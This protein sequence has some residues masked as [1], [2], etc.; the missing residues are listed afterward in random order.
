MRFKQPIILV[1]LLTTSLLI[2]SIPFWIFDLNNNT[3]IVLRCDLNTSVENLIEE[4]K[5]EGKNFTVPEFLHLY[6]EVTKFHFDNRNSSDYNDLIPY[7]V[8][9]STFYDLTP[10]SVIMIYYTCI[11]NTKEQ[12]MFLVEMDEL[13]PEFYSFRKNRMENIKYSQNLAI[14]VRLYFHILLVNCSAQVVFATIIAITYLILWERHSLHG[15]LQLCYVLLEAIHRTGR[16]IYLAYFVEDKGAGNKYIY[17]ANYLESCAKFDTFAEYIQISKLFW[18]TILVFDLWKTFGRGIVLLGK[19]KSKFVKYFA[20]AVLSPAVYTC[21]GLI[22]QAW[23]WGYDCFYLLER[24]NETAFQIWRNTPSI[25]LFVCNLFFVISCYRKS[26]VM[27]KEGEFAQRNVTSRTDSSSRTRYSQV[28]AQVSPDGVLKSKYNTDCQMQSVILPYREGVMYTFG[29]KFISR[30]AQGE[31]VFVDLKRS[32]W[33]WSPDSMFQIGCEDGDF[34]VKPGEG[35]MVIKNGVI[36]NK[37]A[38]PWL[39]FGDE[40]G[41]MKYRND[42]SGG[43]AMFSF[44]ERKYTTNWDKNGRNSAE[45]GP[46]NGAGLNFTPGKNQLIFSHIL[47]HLSLGNLKNARLVCKQWDEQVSPLVRKK[48]IIRFSNYCTTPSMRFSWVSHPGPIGRLTVH[49]PSQ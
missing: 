32:Q 30:E 9:N 5:Q 2:L 34:F 15:H 27:Q 29:D 45:S 25:F 33:N 40:L 1:V 4:F 28:V 6:G 48:S 10:N 23:V 49:S 12:V 46:E 36:L 44:Q 3:P 16:L 39:H 41:F 24:R 17:N 38:R 18:L 22:L 42:I 31:F 35:N 13:Y 37:T 14:R 26:K 43:L 21:A 19:R 20:F 8:Y 11:N 47:S 7:I